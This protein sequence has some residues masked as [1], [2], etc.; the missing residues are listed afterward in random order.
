MHCASNCTDH[1]HTPCL[2]L[3][4]SLTYTLPPTVRITY[5]H[6]LC[7]QLYR[8]LTYI[9]SASNCTDHLR[10][11]TLPPTVQITY[12]HTLCLQLYRSLTYT[13]PPTVQIT[14]IHAASNSIDRSMSLVSNLSSR[15]PW[16]SNSARGS[17]QT[18]RSDLN[19]PPPDIT[20]TGSEGEEIHHKV[21]R[22]VWGG[23]GLFVCVCACVCERIHKY[24]IH[25][26]KYSIN[27]MCTYV[28]PC[29]I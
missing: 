7:L 1:L 23:K 3:Y 9:H 4:R 2:Q 25:T 27:Y 13:L 8:S 29:A 6:T 28:C 11:Y 22:C 15:I 14:Y 18:S 5:V 16:L 21:R 20:V 19:A 24:V 26:S 17:P 12:V 10:T